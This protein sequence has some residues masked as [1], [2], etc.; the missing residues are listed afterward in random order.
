MR[1][2][3]KIENNVN[4]RKF[5]TAKSRKVVRAKFPAKPP[6][7]FALKN[8]PCSQGEMQDAMIRLKDV[9]RLVTAKA[10]LKSFGYEKLH[11]VKPAD[12]REIIQAANEAVYEF[13]H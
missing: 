11:D 7:M 1:K 10:L 3:W 12:Y 9:C 2:F 5:E 13:T 8:E 4:Q 6:C